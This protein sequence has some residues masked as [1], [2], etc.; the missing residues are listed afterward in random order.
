MTTLV[1]GATGFIGHALVRH[2]LARGEPVRVL[3]RDPAKWEALGVDGVE[4]AIGDITDRQA[5]DRAIAGTRRLFAIAGTFREPNLSD[6]QYREINVDAVRS[7]LEIAQRHGL[8]RVIHCSTVGIH[9]SIEGMPATEDAP[10]VPE[11][12]YE[13]TKA[14]GDAVA[15]EWQQRGELD[16]VVVRP[17]PVY[18]PGDTR[19]LKMF[20]LARRNPI[21]IF[22]DGSA[23]YHA[24]YI[25]DLAELLVRAM[26]AERAAGQTFIA[27]GP[28][29]PTIT[30]L[31]TRLARLLGN[32]S[33]KFLRLPAGP[34]LLAADLCETLCR[35]VGLAP[36]L[37]RRRVQFF[38]NNR[39]YDISRARRL[40]GWRPRVGLEDGLARTAAWYATRGV[41]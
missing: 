40:L 38:L 34:A 32:S 9:G 1:T 18:G 23:R 20:K 7:K 4:V 31:L 29:A 24:I 26:W 39:H 41:L 17:A 3:V 15:R 14:A 28:E 25:D 21:P 36:P 2:L 8:E 13:E 37:Y 5:L 27:A 19:L 10:I 33:P 11:G 35:P 16:V 12:I 30:G 6:E 22:G